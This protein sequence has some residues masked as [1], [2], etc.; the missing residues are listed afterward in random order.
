MDDAL[1]K[2]MRAARECQQEV[3]GHR[4]TCMRPTEGDLSEKTYD[5]GLSI[6]LDFVTGWDLTEADLIPSG[7]PEPVEFT[8][9]RWRAWLFDHSEVWNPLSERIL[10]EY[11]RHQEKKAE[12]GKNSEPGSS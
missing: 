7:G 2:R 3:N 10:N 12:A 8:K 5:T 4:F 11:T 9:D 6:L 1:V